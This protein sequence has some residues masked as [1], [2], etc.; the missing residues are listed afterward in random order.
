[1]FYKLNKKGNLNGK[2]RR[3]KKI[4]Q[5]YLLNIFKFRII[6]LRKAMKNNKFK[7]MKMNGKKLMKKMKVFFYKI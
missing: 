2:L 1:M 7:M 4:F 6:N 5:E 3:K